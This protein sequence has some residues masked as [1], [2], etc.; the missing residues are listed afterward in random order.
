MNRAFEWDIHDTCEFDNFLMCFARNLVLSCAFLVL[1]S[2]KAWY[3]KCVQTRGFLSSHMLQ[4]VRWDSVEYEIHAPK[5]TH[6]FMLGS[7][8]HETVKFVRISYEFCA[9]FTR[10]CPTLHCFAFPQ[11]SKLF[12]TAFCDHVPADFVAA[13]LLVVPPPSCC[14]HPGTPP[15]PP[16]RPPPNGGGNLPVGGTCGG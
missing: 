4:H 10:I 13:R 6:K 2:P 5:F 1:S 14:R 9:N 8:I 15:S 7:Q 11:L 3:N 16:R 12:S